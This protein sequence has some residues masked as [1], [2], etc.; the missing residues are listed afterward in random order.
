MKTTPQSA[1]DY[2]ALMQE[3]LALSEQWTPY[4]RASDRDAARMKVLRE[5][6]SKHAQK[7]EAK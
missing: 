7:E 4:R 2:E 1:H 5:L 6:L 3:Y